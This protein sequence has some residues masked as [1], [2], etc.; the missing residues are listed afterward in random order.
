MTSRE[1]IKDQFLRATPAVLGGAL[2][3]A[4]GSGAYPSAWAP[5]PLAEQ[6]H[7]DGEAVGQDEPHRAAER[8]RIPRV[9]ARRS[10]VGA[11]G[12]LTGEGWS[13][14]AHRPGCRDSVRRLA[15][16]WAGPARPRPLGAARH[17]RSRYRG[18]SGPARPAGR[19]WPQHRRRSRSPPMGRRAGSV[20]SYASVLACSETPS[21]S[22]A[23]SCGQDWRVHS[24]HSAARGT[25]A[26]ATGGSRAHSAVWVHPGTP[27]VGRR[28]GGCAEPG[29][30]G[31]G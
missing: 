31:Q 11:A 6:P 5:A 28:G 25:A 19:A 14:G 23:L 30:S 2:W 26:R 27:N 4:F 24:F 20:W 17:Q 10:R 21:F 8:F 12:E 29:R 15:S 1:R 13:S 22:V 18:R 7:A 9:P 16:C 3:S